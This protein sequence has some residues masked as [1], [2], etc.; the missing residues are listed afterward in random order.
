MAIVETAI[1]IPALFAVA[2]V[3]AWA[4]SLAG[5]ALTLGDAVRQAARD[6]ARGVGTDTA[7]AAA[8]QRAPG[9]RI[10]VT[11]GAGTVLV[12]AD[13][14]VTAPVITSITVTVHQQVAVPAEWS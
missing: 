13:Q 14:D 5:T 12:T 7:L 2:L 10:Q 11:A 9:A 8:Q 3:L 4:V 1:A 6:V